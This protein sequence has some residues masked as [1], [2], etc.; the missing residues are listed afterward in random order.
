[1]AEGR[2]V[3]PEDLELRDFADGAG[4][5]TL[6][7]ARETAEREVILAA[8]QRGGG[9]ISRAAEDLGISRPTLY[10]LMEKLGIERAGEEKEPA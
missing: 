5:M 3:T 1:M 10:E 9:K 6:K 2:Y 7:Q 4:I 8:L